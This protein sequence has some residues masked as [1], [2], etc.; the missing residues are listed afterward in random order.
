MDR[1]NRTRPGL[2][3]LANRPA[4][5]DCTGGSV[6]RTGAHCGKKTS[7]RYRVSLTSELCA[8]RT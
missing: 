3:D 2:H 6:H 5:E 1:A 4:D 8:I 7:P